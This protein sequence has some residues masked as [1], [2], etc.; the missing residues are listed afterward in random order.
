[1]QHCT[2]K[3]C[4]PT[5]FQPDETQIT[6]DAANTIFLSPYLFLYLYLY[7]I[8]A[9]LFIVQDLLS[10]RVLLPPVSLG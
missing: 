6:N 1:M 5:Q 7:I 10:A 8:C 4:Y 3:H 9:H 2:T